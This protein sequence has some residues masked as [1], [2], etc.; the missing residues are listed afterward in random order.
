MYVCGPT[1]YDY[2]HLGH[3][4]SAVNFDVIRRYLKFKGYKVNFIFNYTDIDDKIIE[5]ANKDNISISD[6]YNSQ[7]VIGIKKSF[8]RNNPPEECQK[9]SWYS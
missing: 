5:R 2:G 6:A 3:G 7:K 9:C 8:L 4:R 1:I